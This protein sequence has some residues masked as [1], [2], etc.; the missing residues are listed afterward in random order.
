MELTILLLQLLVH[1]L[2]LERD[3]ILDL[4]LFHEGFEP[5]K[6]DCKDLEQIIFG[7]HIF[8]NVELAHFVCKAH[9]ADVHQ[10]GLLLL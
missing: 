8:H 2:H 6:L 1:V 3:L 9:Q 4:A 10:N 7:Q 5:I